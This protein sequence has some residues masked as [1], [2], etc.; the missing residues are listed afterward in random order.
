M[1]V[2]KTQELREKVLLAAINGYA[3]KGFVPK[4]VV[5][6]SIEVADSF[7]VDKDGIVYQKSRAD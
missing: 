7:H 3:A 6:H 4:T 1:D 2:K 5:E